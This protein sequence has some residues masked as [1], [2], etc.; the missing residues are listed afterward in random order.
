MG[1]LIVLGPVGHREVEWDVAAVEAKDPEAL[2]AVREAE[3]ILE[4]AR[5]QGGTAFRVDAPDRPAERLD[6]FDRTAEQIVV[7]PQIAGG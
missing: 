2:A 3:R 7:V 5:A 4:Q 1:K 6:K